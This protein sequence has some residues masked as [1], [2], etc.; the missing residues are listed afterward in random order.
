MIVSL[1][2]ANDE[3]PALGAGRATLPIDTLGTAAPFGCQAPAR[4]V[5]ENAAHYL[6]GDCKEL[7]AMIP[8]HILGIP[9]KLNARS[10]GKPNGIPG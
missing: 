1:I 2:V 10:E 5:E 9:T 4:A 6:C 3:L 8:V 7:G